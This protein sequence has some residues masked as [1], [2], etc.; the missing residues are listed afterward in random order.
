MQFDLLC[1]KCIL[2]YVYNQ[3]FKDYS[4]KTVE[5]LN[6]QKYL[7]FMEK[8][9]NKCFLDEEKKLNKTLDAMN[10]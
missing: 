6:V 10:K 9:F 4:A 1:Y 2:S 3:Q 8:M 5:T 7:V